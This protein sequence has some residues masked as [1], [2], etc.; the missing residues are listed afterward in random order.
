MS[1]L[2]TA[3][4]ELVAKEKRVFPCIERGKEPAIADNLKRATTDP[5]VIAGWWRSRD[6]NIGLATGEGS[7]VS[8]LD[9]DGEEGEATLKRLESEHGGL[10]PTVEAIT[11]K[12]RHIYFRWPQGLEIRNFQHRDDVPGIDV[13]GNGGYVLAPPSLIRAAASIRGRSR[14]PTSSPTRRS[15]CLIWLP[16]K[17]AAAMRRRSHP[18][19]CVRSSIKPTRPAGAAKQSHGV[20]LSGAPRRRSAGGAQFRVHGRRTAQ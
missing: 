16:T 17:A 5:N 14:A 2:G 4:L 20:R 8:V 12:G 7:G 15:G 19:K 10:P 18:S 9:I 6:F 1:P 3:A 11:G 13:R